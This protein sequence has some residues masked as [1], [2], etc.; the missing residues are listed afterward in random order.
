MMLKMKAYLE[1]QNRFVSDVSHELRTPLAVLDGHINLLNRWG[2]N[3]P[4]VL[5]ESLQ[6]SLD[7]VDRMKKMLEEMLALARLEN[8]DLSSEEL[9][10]DV[11]KVCNRA[12]K[13][14]Q[15]LHDDFEIVLD[16]RL[17]Y[18]TH[19]RISENHFEQGLR[20]LLDNAA[21]YS[22][23]DRKE[24]VITVSEDEQ[25][26]ITSVSDKGIGISEEDINHLFERFFRADKA[27]NREIGGTGL[28]L[29]I[30]ARLA[31]NYQGE[32]EVNSELGLGSTFTLKFP[33]I[34]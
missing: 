6:A 5:D 13:N 30:L 4:E 33:K 19:A 18:P 24:I 8:V 14:F 17:I 28:G 34:K 16:N 15:L 12:L 3:D 25:F 20:I 21:K 7:E 32:I 27:R 22:P 29:P 2:K 10:C 11:G 26:V 31:E 9:D 1:Q 23:D